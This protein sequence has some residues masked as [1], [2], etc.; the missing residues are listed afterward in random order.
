[1]T[2]NPF[3]QKI[4]D[5][6]GNHKFDQKMPKITGADANHRLRSEIHQTMTDKKDKE[7]SLQLLQYVES[8]TQVDDLPDEKFEIPDC[9]EV[10]SDKMDKKFKAFLKQLLG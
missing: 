3:F 5:Y 2:L 10:D 9:N 1:M 4:G 7:S 8:I 6:T